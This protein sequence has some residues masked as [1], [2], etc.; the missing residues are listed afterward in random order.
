M[1]MMRWLSAALLVLC[2]A[3]ES[4]PAQPQAG[5]P[6]ARLQNGF[7]PIGILGYPLGD[8]L[9][10]EGTRGPEGGKGIGFGLLVDTINGKKLKEPIGIGLG[11]ITREL[12]KNT[13]ILLKGYETGQMIGVVPAVIAWQQAMGETVLEPQ[14]GWQWRSAFIVLQAVKPKLEFREPK[15]FKTLKQWHEEEKKGR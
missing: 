5:P 13:R 12:P 3:G 10:V 14:A 4:L 15:G 11:N 7:V 9:T 1:K 6:R 2:L 8:Y